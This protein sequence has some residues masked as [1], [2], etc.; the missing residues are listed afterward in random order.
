MGSEIAKIAEGNQW[1]GIIVNR[2]YSRYERDA[3]VRIRESQF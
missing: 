1:E 2:V 3:M